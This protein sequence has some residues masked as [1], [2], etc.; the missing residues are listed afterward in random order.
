M[1]DNLRLIYVGLSLL[2]VAG[3]SET[4]TSPSATATRS[5]TPA[6]AP[7]FDYSTIGSSFGDSRSSFVVTPNGG[8]FSVGGLFTV[9][10]PAGSICDPDLSS[11]GEGTWDSS[12]VPLN[13]PILI[14]GTARLGLSGMGA[15]FQPDM[16]FVPSKQV[17]I[18]TDVFASL[19]RANASFFAKYP[20]TLRPLAVYYTPTLG[21]TRVA[22]YVSDPTLV[23]HIDLTT[24]RIW[25]RVKH[26]SGYSQTTGL[27]CDPSPGDPDCID[28]QQQ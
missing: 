3:C 4:S 10:F 7:A 28:V 14:T 24:G 23:T 15:D 18:S 22:D 9:N 21:G 11:Y 5:F 27:A 25:R 13:R 6:D 1:R 19:I 20:S 16:R 12:C 8:S 26:F 2:I 17:T